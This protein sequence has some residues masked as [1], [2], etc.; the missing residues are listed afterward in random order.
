MRLFPV[1]I[2]WQSNGSHFSQEIYKEFLEK[3]SEEIS[4]EVLLI[5]QYL[6]VFN[7]IEPFFEDMVSFSIESL[8]SKNVQS[9]FQRDSFIFY[10]WHMLY[11]GRSF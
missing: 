4:Q 8:Q 3:L 7:S 5:Y 10:E 1:E 6:A 9:H 11:V 2:Q